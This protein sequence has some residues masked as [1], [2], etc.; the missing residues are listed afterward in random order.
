MG[1]YLTPFRDDH[2][3]TDQ[4]GSMTPAGSWTTVYGFT[5][6]GI[7][8]LLVACFNFTNLATARATLRARE[9][10]LRKVMGATRRQLSHAQWIEFSLVGAL[11]GLLAAGG[12]ATVGAVLARQVFN[13][14]WTFHPAVW[15]AGM[16]VG[17]ACALG[18]GWIGLRNVLSHPP[19]QSLREA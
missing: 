2:L 4:Y 1:P 17:V 9:I 14:E 12:A 10:S 3:S 18:G 16:S 8:I 5:A 13:F 11:S 6:I 7:L 15:L 19:L